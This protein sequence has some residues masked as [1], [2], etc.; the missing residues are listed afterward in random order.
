MHGAYGVGLLGSDLF[1]TE[2][3]SDPTGLGQN[4]RKLQRT[5]INEQSCAP[6]AQL[7]FADMLLGCKDSPDI[8]A[9]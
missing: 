3:L 5:Q 2:L 1:L 8:F 4:Q 7:G 9:L 6:V